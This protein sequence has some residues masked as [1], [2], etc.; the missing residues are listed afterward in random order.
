MTVTE[1]NISGISSIRSSFLADIGEITDEV[2]QAQAPAKR[3][4][5]MVRKARSNEQGNKQGQESG[6]G[7]TAH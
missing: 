7:N 5:V 1:S 6:T 2:I 3:E 4:P